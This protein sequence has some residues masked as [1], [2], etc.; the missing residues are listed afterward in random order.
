MSNEFREQKKTAKTTG[1]QSTTMTGVFGWLE[2]RFRMEGVFKQ[3][4]P[5]NYLPYIL[6]VALL[7][8]IYIGN[9]HYSERLNKEYKTK[10]NEL[11]GLKAKYNT[12][13]AEYM[14]ESKQSQIENKVKPAGI[15]SSKK[16]P[17]IIEVQ[18]SEY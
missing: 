16:A 10:R 6:F 14:Y 4:L 18:E 1:S 12:L 3:G 8:V 15:V 2:K 13:K 7:G 17:V 9:A 5:V 11:E